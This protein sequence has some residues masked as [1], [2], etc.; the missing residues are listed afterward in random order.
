MGC[1]RTLLVF[2][3][4]FALTVCIYR[5]DSFL[6]C[7]RLHDPRNP[8]HSSV[9]NICFWVKDYMDILGIHHHCIY[10]KVSQAWLR[11][12][13]AILREIPMLS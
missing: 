13:W 6:H 7:R 12:S 10:G 5:Y 8:F 9:Q 1:G 4:F 11:G 2:L 3:L